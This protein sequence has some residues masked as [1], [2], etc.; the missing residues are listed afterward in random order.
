MYL[1]IRKSG[2]VIG[3]LKFEEGPI[4]IGRQIGSQV[5]LPDKNVSRQHAVFYTDNDG[6]WTLEDLGSTNKTFIG[7]NAVNKYQI[8]DGDIIHIADFTIEVEFDPSGTEEQPLQSLDTKDSTVHLEDTIA[9]A[10]H[11]PVHAVI[12]DFKGA[13]A[14]PVKIPAKRIVDFASATDA[15]CGADDIKQLHSELLDILL[16]QF[17][18]FS[19]WVAL[20]RDDL[21]PMET[22]GGRKITR[23]S[24]ILTELAEQQ[25]VAEAMANLRYTL[26]PQVAKKYTKLGIRSAIIAPIVRKKECDG[27]LYVDNSTK[28]EHYSTT[29][30]DYLVLLAVHTAAVLKRL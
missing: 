29:D 13:N 26:I 7:N 3:R 14:G 15:I 17:S 19:A 16:R 22:Q 20:R 12:R 21:G 6:N 18:G 9:A 25:C 8:D 10:K 11:E 28:H 23:E 30:L 5:F 1:C 2:S 27:V 4:Y 24:V